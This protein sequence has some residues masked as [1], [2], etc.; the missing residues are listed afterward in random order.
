[1]SILQLDN[2]RGIS[3]LLF[4]SS[5]AQQKAERIGAPVLERVFQRSASLR[6]LPVVTHSVIGDRLALSELLM[7]IGNPW[8][9]GLAKEPIE[10]RLAA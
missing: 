8:A 1:V 4:W 9:E 5:L 2:E 7:R 3:K 6:E 10:S